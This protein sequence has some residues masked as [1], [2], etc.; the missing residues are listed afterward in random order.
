[1]SKLPS[2]ILVLSFF[3]FFSTPVL[4]QVSTSSATTSGSPVGPVRLLTGQIQDLRNKYRKSLEVYRNDERLYTIA[5]GQYVQLQTLAS[6]EEA[7]RATRQVMLSRSDVMITYFTLLK[8]TLMDT[9]G[10]DVNAKKVQLAKLDKLLN[11]LQTHQIHVGTA[12]DRPSI[13][14]MVGEFAPIEKQAENISTGTV[15]LISYGNIQAVYD[16]T[17]SVKNE[18][19]TEIESNEPDPLQLATKKRGLDEIDRQLDDVSFQLKK[20]QNTV[21]S[22]QN[23]ASF[24]SQTTQ[25]NLSSIYSALSRTLSLLGEIIQ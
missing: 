15:L 22:S 12:T 16:K 5:R 7:V 3:C 20:T 6:L 21:T 23:D 4:A 24:Y 9:P 25:D 14:Q 17:I 10:I 8:V 1:M 11:D 13:A 18:I 2:I 19:R